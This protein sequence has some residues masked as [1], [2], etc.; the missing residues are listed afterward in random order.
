MQHEDG[1]EAAAGDPQQEAKLVFEEVRVSIDGV[2]ALK[3][4]QV[5]DHVKHDVERQAQSGERYQNL[6]A[7]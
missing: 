2:A 6:R 3:D 5:A 4:L 1:Q 7:H